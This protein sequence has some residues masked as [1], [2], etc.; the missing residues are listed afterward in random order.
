LEVFL[1]I[2][3]AGSLAG[4]TGMILAIPVYTILRVFAAEFLSGVRLVQKLTANME[5]G[6]DKN[7]GKDISSN[8][9]E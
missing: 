7:R 9:A 8:K 5:T 6:I 1:V 3:A 4:I 2:M